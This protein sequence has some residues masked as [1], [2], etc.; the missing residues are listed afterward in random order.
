M[1]KVDQFYCRIDNKKRLLCHTQIPLAV[2]VHMNVHGYKLRNV[3][4]Q[5]CW[6][7]HQRETTRSRL[8]NYVALLLVVE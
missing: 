7:G 8:L 3:L 5:L 6:L 1:L 2:L 4:P